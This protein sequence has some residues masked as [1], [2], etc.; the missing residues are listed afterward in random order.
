MTLYAN[1]KRNL[2]V[3]TTSLV[4]TALFG[5]FA[6]FVWDSDHHNFVNILLAAGLL[7]VAIV[8]LIVAII[9]KKKTFLAAMDILATFI[10]YS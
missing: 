8:C 2:G 4:L 9:G 3:I 6:Y 7:V 1:E 5:M 10:W